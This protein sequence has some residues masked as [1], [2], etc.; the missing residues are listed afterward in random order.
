MSSGVEKDGQAGG[1]GERLFSLNTSTS[2]KCYL[3]T[4]KPIYYTE[5]THA[6]IH[7]HILCV[8]HKRARRKTRY[9]A[10]VFVD[11][12]LPVPVVVLVVVVRV[13][14]SSFFPCTMFFGRTESPRC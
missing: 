4:A 10:D 6:N 14:V 13:A 3:I 2:R 11:D 7:I 8:V 12:F 9:N 1:E 5:R